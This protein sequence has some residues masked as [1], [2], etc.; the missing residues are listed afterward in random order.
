MEAGE[1]ADAQLKFGQHAIDYYRD[2]EKKG[3]GKKDFG[4]VYRYIH[5]NFEI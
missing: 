5:K 2:I 1:Q 4:F 3:F